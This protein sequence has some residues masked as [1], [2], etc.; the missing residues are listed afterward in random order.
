MVNNPSAAEERQIKYKKRVAR[1]RN[2]IKNIVFVSIQI[3]RRFIVYRL[4][5]LLV[6]QENAALC[7]QVAHMQETILCVK[8]ER[9]FLMRKLIEL[10]NDIPIDAKPNAMEQQQQQQ[11]QKQQQQLQHKQANTTATGTPQTPSPQAPRTRK[12]YKKRTQTSCA[13]APKTPVAIG[14]TTATTSK[15][16]AAPKKP[17]KSHKKQLQKKP[18]NHQHDQPQHQQLQTDSQQNADMNDPPVEYQLNGN[19]TEHVQTISIDDL[20]RP[21]YPIQMGDNLA[22]FDLGEIVASRIH[23]QNEHWLYPVGYMATRI[24][25]HIK[26]PQRKCVYTCKITDGGDYPL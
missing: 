11:H 26:E 8:E 4:S 7:D 1:I 13:L 9:K 14:D 20:G 2:I 22:I 23:Y 21:I 18:P 16:S 19:E 5:F 3:Q 24:Y 25:G 17:K 15:E 10:D 6:C 12:P